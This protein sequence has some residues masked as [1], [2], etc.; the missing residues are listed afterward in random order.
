[1]PIL[2]GDWGGEGFWVSGCT[3][4]VRAKCCTVYDEC[5]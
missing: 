3:M 4:R 5:S 1:M 2:R